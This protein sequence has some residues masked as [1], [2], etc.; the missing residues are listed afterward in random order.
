MNKDLYRYQ[1]TLVIIGTGVMVFGIWSVVRTLMY[2]FLNHQY[3][4]LLKETSDYGINPVGLQLPLI[5][6]LAIDLS[7]R[8]FSGKC[9]RSFGKEGTKFTA[10]IVSAIVLI[11]IGAMSIL[12][13]LASFP[14]EEGVLDNVITLFIDVTSLVLLIEMLVSAVNAKRLEAQKNKTGQGA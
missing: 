5:V 11:I 10:C 9:A 8:L 14:L 4:Q 1:N 12:R 7:L 6:I 2:L 13:M 3:L